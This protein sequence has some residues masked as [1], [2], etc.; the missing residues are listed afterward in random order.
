[1]P[2]NFLTSKY[3]GVKSVTNMMYGQRVSGAG[4]GYYGGER[5]LAGSSETGTL[6]GFAG[7]Y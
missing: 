5:A 4:K 7:L 6:I 2:A 1:M 3:V